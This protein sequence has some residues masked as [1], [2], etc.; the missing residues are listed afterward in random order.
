MYSEKQGSDYYSD[1]RA[2]STLLKTIYP[3]S[4]LSYDVG[5]ITGNIRTS[6]S[7]DE[8]RPFHQKFYRPENLT[9]IITGQIEADQVFEAL[10]PIQEKVL[11][12]P[13][14]VTFEKPWQIPIGSIDES[15]DI[16]VRNI[17]LK[18]YYF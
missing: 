10:R 2:R 14:R 5:G 15:K 4:G 18:F 1:I 17:Y 3:D 11:S 7:M 6:T 8:I 12:K 13:K 16:K 9:L